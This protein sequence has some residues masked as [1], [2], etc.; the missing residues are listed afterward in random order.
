MLTTKTQ[1]KKDT[2]IVSHVE[3]I[4][5]GWFEASGYIKETGQRIGNSSTI[6][7]SR[8]QAVYNLW[9]YAC[10]VYSKCHYPKYDG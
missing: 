4:G 1:I 9:K 8:K 6:G 5:Q 7:R 2:L 3:N 10:D